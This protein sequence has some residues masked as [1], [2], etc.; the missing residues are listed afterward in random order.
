M[1]PLPG[2]GCCSGTNQTGGTGT[3]LQILS[4]ESGNWDELMGKG[5]LTSV[6]SQVKAYVKCEDVNC[7][8]L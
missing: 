2:Y 8:Y 7:I 3:V 4:R 5:E 6:I 1:L